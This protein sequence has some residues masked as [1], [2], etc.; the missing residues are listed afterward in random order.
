PDLVRVPVF[1][2]PDSIR[3]DPGP[4]HPESPARLE[5]VV[6]RLTSAAFADIR[7]SPEAAPAD[8]TA[9][10]DAAYLERL[11]AL[12]V[13]GGGSL[14]VDTV[15]NADSWRAALRSAGGAVA[16]VESALATGAPAFSAGRPPGHHALR[17]QSM[18]FCLLANAVIAARAGQR[19]GAPEVLIVDWDV[20]HG[21]G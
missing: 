12:A 11:E 4:G 17:A 1:T 21:N 9:V 10:H 13:R 18:G 14:D 2:H 20:H 16:A 6:Q 15:M 5:A 7:E 19:L 8:L 3:H